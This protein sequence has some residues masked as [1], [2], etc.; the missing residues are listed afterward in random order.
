MPV[1]TAGGEVGAASSGLYTGSGTGNFSHAFAVATLLGPVLP[2][3]PGTCTN[4]ASAETLDLDAK[5]T[6][7]HTG[8]SHYDASF[9][10]AFALAL[11]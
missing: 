4:A 8:L 11:Q 1:A 2:D 5:A 3:H 6:D 9:V 10:R 7:G